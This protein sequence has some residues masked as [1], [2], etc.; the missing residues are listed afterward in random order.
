[1]KHLCKTFFLSL[2]L[3]ALAL[4]PAT[5]QKSED[6]MAIFAEL[7]DTF[8]YSSGVGA[9]A[10]EMSINPDGTFAGQ[11]HDSDMGT[12]GEG[13]PHGTVYLSNFYGE[14]SAPAKITDTVYS[15]DLIYV[16]TQEEIDTSEIIDQIRYVYSP[17]VGIDGGDTFYLYLPGT[18][19]SSLPD[20]ALH[21]PLWGDDESSSIIPEGRCVLYNSESDICFMGYNTNYYMTSE[22]APETQTACEY[23]LPNVSNRYYSSEEIYQLTLQEVNYAKNEIYAIHGRKFKSAELRSFF[24]SKS[25]YYGYVDGND[26]S[27]TVFNKYERANLELLAK[28]ETQ[29]GGPDG[30]HLDQ[31][32][33]DYR[34]ARLGYLDGYSGTSEPKQKKTGAVA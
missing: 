20:C 17:A 34:D 31:P 25:W 18:A 4:F 33:A 7:P 12:T 24:E 26:F 1:M 30:Y 8:V 5:A 23:I 32:G 15:L 11:Y 6:N 21:M 29:L 2:S 3:S 16:D 10:S 19:K 28:R 9:W 13:Y 22:P 27:D 14:F